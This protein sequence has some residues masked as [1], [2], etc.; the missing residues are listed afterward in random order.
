MIVSVTSLGSA[1]YQFVASRMPTSE[2]Q[3]CR[4]VGTTNTWANGWW[5]YM[6]PMCDAFA[7]VSTTSPG[8]GWQFQN[9]GSGHTAFGWKGSGSF[10]SAAASSDAGDPHDVWYQEPLMNPLNP[11]LQNTTLSSGIQHDMFAGYKPAYQW[12]SY[13]SHSCNS[14]VPDTSKWTHG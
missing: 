14:Q 7:F 11:F 4:P 13:P 8:S 12:Q 2:T 1:N 10:P 9:I 3:G 5:G 6:Q